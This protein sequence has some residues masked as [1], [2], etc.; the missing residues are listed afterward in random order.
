[1]RIIIDGT[2]EELSQLALRLASEGLSLA[3]VPETQ[4]E[5]KASEEP[6]T[7][8]GGNGKVAG[9]DQTTDNKL[10]CFPGPIWDGGPSR[11]YSTCLTHLEIDL[12]P[13]LLTDSFRL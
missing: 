9:T 1:M 6:T 7:R 3:P 4:P 8:A 11:D 10:W 13:K 5:E 12:G 2:P